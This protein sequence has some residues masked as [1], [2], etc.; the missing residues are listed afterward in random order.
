MIFAYSRI[1]IVLAILRIQLEKEQY[2]KNF[3]NA[4][5]FLGMYIIYVF[6]L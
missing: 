6:M 3:F 1:D 2:V 5:S 4:K